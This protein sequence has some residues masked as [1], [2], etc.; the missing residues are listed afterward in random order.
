[1]RSYGV[2]FRASGQSIRRSGV[3]ARTCLGSACG[4]AR[5]WRA[6][7]QLNF[8]QRLTRR[9]AATRGGERVADRRR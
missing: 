9:P 4:G 5:R 3:V 6:S 1:M 7:A 8:G 2:M